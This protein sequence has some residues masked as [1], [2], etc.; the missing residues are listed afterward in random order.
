M[1]IREKIKSNQKLKDFVLWTLTPKRN[2]RPRLW[3]RWFLNPFIHEKGKKA[4]IR[5]RS[6]IDVFPYNKFSIGD[7]ST[8]EDFTVINNGSGDVIIGNN[9]RVGIGSVIIGPVTLGNGSGLGQHVFISGF[10]HN[11]NDGTKNSSVQGLVVKPVIIEDE[12]HIGANSV[13]TAGVTIGQRTQIGA[14]S[15]VTKN[16]PPFSVA[17]G[18]PC[19]VIKQFN[20]ATNQW[21]KI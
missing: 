4:L 5:G 19:K 7:Y 14:G 13:V 18:N 6:R 16:I 1:S 10:N 21:E 8:I 20:H 2:P 15:V 3:V 9:A 12:V 17:V 11:Y